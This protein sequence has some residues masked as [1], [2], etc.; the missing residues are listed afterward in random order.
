VRGES[1]R[2]DVVEGGLERAVDAAIRGDT[3]AL[4][5]LLA[6]GSHLPGVRP[7][8]DL[9][10][11]FA[12][13]M[14]AR[15]RVGDTLVTALATLHPDRAPGATELE[16]LPLCGVVAAGARGAADEAC[17]PRMLEILDA[18]ACDLRFRVR[19]AV[20]PALARIGAARGETLLTLVESWMDRFFPATAVLLAMTRL[21]W[22]S[23]LERPDLAVRRLEEAFLLARNA[24]RSAERYPGYKALVVALSTAPSELAA[25]FGAPVFDLLARMSDIKEPVLREAILKN[26]ESK[27]LARRYGEDVARVRRALEATAPVARDPRSNVGP[28][29]RRGKRDRRS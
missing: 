12:A 8:L 11:R 21:D 14:V 23:R 25:R 3:R 13:A 6:R 22:L 26:L 5:M 19:D 15:G 9:A 27:R 16:F 18:G 17:L 29:R 28:T 1:R 4:Y 2:G 7:N 20:P 10:D 24:E